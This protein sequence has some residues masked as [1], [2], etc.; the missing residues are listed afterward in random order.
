MS[1][2]PDEPRLVEAFTEIAHAFETEKTPEAMLW[3]ITRA[4]VRTVP[5]CDHAGVLIV[6]AGQ[7]TDDASTDAVPKAVGHLLQMAGEGPCLEAIRERHSIVIDDL[8]SD[9]RWPLFSRPVAEETGV[10]GMVSFR[11]L[12]D[13]DSHSTLNLYSRE[14]KAFDDNAH[15]KGAILAVHATIA[16]TAARDR[17]NNQR[18]RVALDS[19][20]EIGT[21]M[22][23]LMA[24]GK[25][26]RAEAFDVLAGASQRLNIKLRRIAS[27]VVQVGEL[28]EE[29]IRRAT[30]P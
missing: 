20:R 18:L 30:D 11:L 26:T 4:A 29:A 12:V 10:R 17:Q 28:N 15:A 5:R 21:A 13:P 25:L 16:L 3:A 19:N 9:T 22:G 7:I 8:A 2:P 1:N 27:Q 24:Q 23:I 6:Q 14:P